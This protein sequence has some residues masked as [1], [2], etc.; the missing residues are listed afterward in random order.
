MALIPK[1]GLNFKRRK[2]EKT[3]NRKIILLFSK[4]QN[5]K[6]FKLPWNE[7]YFVKEPKE[8]PKSGLLLRKCE[9]GKGKYS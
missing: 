2:N 6:G 5:E 1:S 9:S 7:K 8:K 3:E 4:N